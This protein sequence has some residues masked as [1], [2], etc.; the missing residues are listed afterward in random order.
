MIE[1]GF[2]QRTMRQWGCLIQAVLKGGWRRAA[3]AATQRVRRQTEDF[4]R[5]VYFDEEMRNLHGEN[6]IR[7]GSMI[8]DRLFRAGLVDESTDVPVAIAWSGSFLSLTEFFR[9]AARSKMADHIL[10]FGAESRKR[11]ARPDRWRMPI[12]AKPRAKASPKTRVRRK[13]SHDLT[14]TAG[15]DTGVITTTKGVG[16]NPTTPHQQHL[17]RPTCVEAVILC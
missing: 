14:H 17:E 15:A 13:A 9:L 3:V 7:M 16:T 6:E 1:A 12:A 5:F 8:G 2:N 11:H 4:R 10:T